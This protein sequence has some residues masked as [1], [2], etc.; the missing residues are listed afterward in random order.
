MPLLD[1]LDSTYRLH[2]ES[3]D[4]SPFLL[5]P[6]WSK[7]L[8][9][10][11]GFTA[12]APYQ[13]F[14]L[15]ILTCRARVTYLENHSRVFLCYSGFWP[16]CGQCLMPHTVRSHSPIDLLPIIPLWQH[17][18]PCCS[19][20]S[21]GTLLPQDLCTCSSSAWNVLPTDIL[22]ICSLTSLGLHSNALFSVRLSLSTLFKIPL[23]LHDP[24]PPH[25]CPFLCFIYMVF[26]TICFIFFIFS[27]CS[28][29]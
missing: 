12:T 5:L 8:S 24:P 9:S 6:S 26:I 27:L 29:I 15:P 17:W 16:E 10:P 3:Y 7:T 22:M 28:F 4:C 23:P 13:V 18:S 2:P 19:V 25:P 14:L 1:P 21:W 11:T 20:N